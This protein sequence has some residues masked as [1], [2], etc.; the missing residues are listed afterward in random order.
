MDEDGNTEFTGV[1][2]NGLPFEQASSAEQLRVS[3]AMALGLAPA[4]PDAIKVLLVRDASLLDDNS[5]KLITD[6]TEAAGGQCWL[7][8]VSNTDEE[9]Q[10]IISE[11]GTVMV[12]G[13][14]KGKTN[15]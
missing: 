4:R 9:E 2:F 1:T 7:E 5:L 15:G 14:V 3:V 8:R 13:Q 12:D 11:G 10:L 6:M